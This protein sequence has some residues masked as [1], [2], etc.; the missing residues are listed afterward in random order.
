M[1]YNNHARFFAPIMSGLAAVSECWRVDDSADG[2]DDLDVNDVSVGKMIRS[3]LFKDYD[4]Q[5]TGA[6]SLVAVMMMG[7][8]VHLTL[9]SHH[10]LFLFIFFIAD[11]PRVSAAF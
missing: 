5:G 3:I 11:I 8:F 9:K 7:T 6:Y 10:V 2:T 4:D 1:I